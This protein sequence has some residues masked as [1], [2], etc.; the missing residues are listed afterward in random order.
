VAAV[1]QRAD[2]LADAPDLR[3]PRLQVDVQRA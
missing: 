2:P 1:A 3:D